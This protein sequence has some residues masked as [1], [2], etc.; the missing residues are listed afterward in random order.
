LFRE[1]IANE[2][3]NLKSQLSVILNNADLNAS[4]KLKLYLIKRM[5]VLNSAACYHE[6]L[7]ADFFEHFQNIRS[8]VRLCPIHERPRG[9]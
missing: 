9:E 7:K 1:V 3:M 2:M 4:E 8:L 6:T 5:E